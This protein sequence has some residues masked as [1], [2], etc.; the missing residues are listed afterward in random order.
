MVDYKDIVLLILFIQLFDMSIIF[1]F[2]LTTTYRI[3][4]I[5]LRSLTRYDQRIKFF[6]VWKINQDDHDC[7][8]L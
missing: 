4:S 8:L 3:I 7:R 6:Y 5:A 2:V 1:W